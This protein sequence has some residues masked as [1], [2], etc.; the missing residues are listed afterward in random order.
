MTVQSVGGRRRVHAAMVRGTFRATRTSPGSR[1]AKTNSAPRAAV[2]GR[3]RPSERIA[4]VIVH[5]SSLDAYHARTGLGEDLALRMVATIRQHHGPVIIVDQGWEV[6]LNSQPREIVEAALPANAVRM[7]FDEDTNT[8]ADFERRIVKAP[9]DVRVRRIR[10]G[11]VWFDAI[12]D[13][14]CV[15]E[16]AKRLTRRGFDVRIDVDIAG[17]D[18]DGGQLE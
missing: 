3:V 9:R 14:G 8:W 5:L 12:G 2:D 4:L 17:A 6:G 13:S 11:G 7:E 15:N 10:L 16:T 18:P 1:V